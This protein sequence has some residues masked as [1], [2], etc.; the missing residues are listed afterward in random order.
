[1]KKKKRERETNNNNNNN[2]NARLIYKSMACLLMN[3]SHH[4]STPNLMSASS[5]VKGVSASS[6]LMNGG[7]GAAGIGG[8][9]GGGGGGVTGSSS[10]HDTLAAI[11]VPNELKTLIR[12]IMRIFYSFELYLCVEMLLIYP[13]L[14]EED[15]AELLRLDLKT[16][17]TLSIIIYSSLIY[18]YRSHNFGIL[19]FE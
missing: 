1:M 5:A 13:C 11:V 12:I 4:H 19:L 17:L 16:V 3:S 2:N 9:G 7:G 10:V 14:K 8:V 15:L 18:L 6:A